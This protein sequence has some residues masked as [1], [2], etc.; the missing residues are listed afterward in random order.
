MKGVRLRTDKGDDWWVVV[1]DLVLAQGRARRLR[2]IN[3]LTFFAQHL[4]SHDREPVIRLSYALEDKLFAVNH[5]LSAFRSAI[6][7]YGDFV[8]SKS[9]VR[10]YAEEQ[11]V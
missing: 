3:A 7:S 1:H 2:P 10:E 5:H 11:K 9:Y 4:V 6:G 8:Y